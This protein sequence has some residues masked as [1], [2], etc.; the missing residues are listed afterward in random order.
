MS[1]DA[2]CTTGPIRHNAWASAEE[3]A[4]DGSSMEEILEATDCIGDVSVTRGDANL[5]A[6]NGGYAW[7]VTFL[8]DADWPCEQIGS[9]GLCNSPGDVPKFSESDDDSSK[10]LGTST[11]NLVYGDGDSTHGAV[12][13]LDAADN[14]TRPPGAPEVQTMRVYDLELTASDKFEGNPGFVLSLGGNTSGCILWDASA[15]TVAEQLSNT[16]SLYAKDV[17]VSNDKHSDSLWN[18]FVFH[19]KVVSENTRTECEGG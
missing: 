5:A 13:V 6:N 7:L 19:R 17:V 12:S 10:L 16:N 1:A 9:D 3:S 8:R 4:G 2:V 18:C 11:R 14:K 15:A